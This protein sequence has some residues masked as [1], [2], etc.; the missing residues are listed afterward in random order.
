MQMINPN[1]PLVDLH[2][3]IE[4]SM[5]I[6]TIVDLAHEHDIPLPADDIQGLR[7]FIQIFDPQPGVM[8]FIEKIELAASVLADYA[9][10]QRVSYESVEDAQSEG[11]DYVELRFSPY[12]MADTNG[13]DPVGVV[14]SVVN[15]VHE[16][17]NESGM[18]VNLIGIISRTYGP[19]AAHRE[20]SALLEH[21]DKLV[22][23]DLAG[24]EAAFPGDLFV[25][26]L[27]I[28]R[29]AGWNVTIHAGE[30]SG[31][32]SVLQAI[33]DLGANRIGHAVNAVQDPSLLDIMVEGGIG[34]E[35]NLTSNVQTSTVQD[36]ASHPLRRFLEL[37]LCSTINT[38]DPGISRIDIQYEYEVA[39]PAAGLTTGQIHQA[40]KNGLQ[41]AFLSESER[42]ALVNLYVQEGSS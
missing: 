10:C 34:I 27:K 6:E 36:Y 25:D 5:R 14:E 3:H 41:A 20:L 28:A 8:A 15:G 23:I 21:R 2:R 33:Q 26:H 35:A 29:D 11:L 4:G 42:Q 24:D 17:Q 39:A 30:S 40:Q 13:L 32:E 37:G 22:G 1:F 7:P 19:E 12:F 31:P 16:A 18:R 38:D 9:A